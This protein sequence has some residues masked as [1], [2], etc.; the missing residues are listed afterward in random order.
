MR[1]LLLLSLLLLRILPERRP[2]KRR[3]LSSCILGSGAKDGGALCTGVL[4]SRAEEGRGLCALG[5]VLGLAE[6]REPRCG[7]LLLLLGAA[8]E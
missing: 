4:G 5:L 8:E 7:R 3:S 2:K 6:A 1:R